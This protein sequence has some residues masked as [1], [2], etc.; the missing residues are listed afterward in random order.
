MSSGPDSIGRK[1]PARFFGFR[2]V[3]IFQTDTFENDFSQNFHMIIEIVFEF[4]PIF[5][6]VIAADV[7]VE[8]VAGIFHAVH[9]FRRVFSGFFPSAFILIIVCCG[10]AD[11]QA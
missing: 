11:A 7:L 4:F 10:R 2:R 5:R 9:V 1:I 3:I 6:T 8:F